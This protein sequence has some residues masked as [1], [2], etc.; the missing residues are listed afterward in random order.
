MSNIVIYD[1]N[2]VGLDLFIDSEN[3]LVDLNYEEIVA[4]N[5]GLTPVVITSVAVNSWYIVGGVA[6]G[7]AGAITEAIN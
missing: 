5:G 7:A 1:L 2:T 4:T 3:Y 6:L